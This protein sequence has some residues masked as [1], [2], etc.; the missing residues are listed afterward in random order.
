LYNVLKVNDYQKKM[1]RLLFIITIFTAVVTLLTTPACYPD[2]EIDEVVKR[3][4]TYVS[5][6]DTTI[7]VD[8][9]KL[10]PSVK[11]TVEKLDSLLK[12]QPSSN[13]IDGEKGGTIKLGDDIEAVFPENS[14]SHNGVVSSIVKGKV[15]IQFSILRTKG[16]LVLHNI[17]TIAG[18]K[19]LI[20][21]GVFLITA[22]QNGKELLLNEKKTVRLRYKF[23]VTDPKMQLFEG[24]NTSRFGGLDWSLI[25]SNNNEIS[26]WLDSLKNT[27]GFEVNIDRL[28]STSCSKP[29]DGGEKLVDDFCITM[30]N[31]EFNNVNTSVFVVFKDMFSVVRLQG[32]P[33]R[34]TF[35]MP[36]YY[37]G[38]PAGKAVHLVAISELKGKTYMAL[39]DTTITEGGTV[40]LQPQVYN[41]E[42]IKLKLKNL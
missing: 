19:L 14:C 40:K 15:D 1:K 31:S 4:S 5:L 37:R 18:G 36:S 30:A 29:Y 23:R 22:S 42:E 17:N 16:E 24:K 21:G 12:T 38:L 6:Q 35:C 26:L 33:G 13:I 9:A 32:N 20:S 7:W 8:I 39:T 11:I 34:K 28:G 27:I 2:K 41:L 10:P 25:S 3:D